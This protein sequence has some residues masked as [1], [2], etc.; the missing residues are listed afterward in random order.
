MTATILSEV[1]LFIVDI[2]RALRLPVIVAIA[3]VVV[4]CFVAVVFRLYPTE[5]SPIQSFNIQANYKPPQ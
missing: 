4:L 1:Y 3:S 5:K 2:G